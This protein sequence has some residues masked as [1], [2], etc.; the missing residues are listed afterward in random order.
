LPVVFLS[1]K[2]QL[3]KIMR[4]QRSHI[5]APQVFK[6]AH[7]VQMPSNKTF[8]SVDVVDTGKLAAYVGLSRP[9]ALA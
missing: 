7:K 3:E 2:P 5:E 6:G 1:T 4:P 9:R 8:P